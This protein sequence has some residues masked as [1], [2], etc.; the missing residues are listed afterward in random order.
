MGGRVRPVPLLPSE[1]PAV[2]VP[3]VASPPAPPPGFGSHLSP[4]PRFQAPGSPVICSSQPST[5]ALSQGP[6][7]GLLRPPYFGAAPSP[8]PAWSVRSP[9]QGCW[10]FLS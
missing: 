6:P 7:H 2:P 3:T 1:G 5:P 9:G 4:L 8:P 10:S